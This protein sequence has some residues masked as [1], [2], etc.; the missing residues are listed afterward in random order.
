M[1][2]K[3]LNTR[4][5]ILDLIEFHNKNSEFV[6]IDVETTSVEPRKARL[7]DIQIS[8]LTEESAVIFGA[9]FSDTLLT[10]APSLILVA[11]N[12]R[13]DAHVLVRHGVDLLERTWRDTL[14]LGHLVDE[15]RDSYSLA[16]YVSEYWG[17]DYK[18]S[19][20][21]KDGGKYASYEE[22]TEE[23]KVEYAC[24]DIVYT[25]KLYRFLELERARVEIPVS[26]VLHAHKLQRS[27]LYTE[28]DGIGVDIAY[29]QDLGV[30][31]KQRID[32]LD[33][34]MRSCVR[35]EIDIIELEMYLKKVSTYKTDKG[36]RGA[37]R[38]TFSY[39]SSAQ[40][41]RLL[42]D[43]LELPEQ[44]NDKTKAVSTD[45]ASLEKI[46]ELH[47]VVRL[48]QDNRDLQKV[49]SSYVIGTLDR[50][51]QSRIYPSF[52]INGTV[53]GRISHHS[54]NLAQLPK[55]GGVRGL[56][57]PSD[58]RVF[59]S[60]DYS[61]L[62]IVIEANLTGDKNLIRMLENGES[63]HDFTAS[64]L[65]CDR[66]TAKTLNL[67]L[68]Y[69]C[70]AGKVAKLLGVS[71][72]EGQ[73]VY[74]QYWNLYSGSRDLKKKTDKAV[75]DG[76]ALTTVFGR[77]RRFEK[78]TRSVF[79]GDYRQAFNFL[80]QSTGADC[81]HEAF[82]TTDQILRSRGFGKTVLEVHDEIIIEVNPLF[83]PEAEKILLATMASVADRFN[84]VVPLRAVS[85]GPRL[86]WEDK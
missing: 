13:Y 82:Y 56:Y 70:T 71:G 54:P 41:R 7:V 8:G 15:N 33:P 76:V 19:F 43:V 44:R 38:P 37:Q 58:G 81:T 29:L 26:L 2:F 62:E 84:F 40:V 72:A 16:S 1:D 77:K 55:T 12:Y 14:L 34:Q 85:S 42:Y 79:D 69:H 52:R 39:D 21:K 22:A 49:Y 83:S 28:I 74:D 5:E 50:L 32:E 18:K 9:E 47:P 64:Q 51:D 48:I 73:R 27:L 78:K 17:S 31:L 36:K 67:A 11:H 30:R 63:K 20:W 68:Q 3:R 45:Y 86:R 23:D 66:N 46:K 80:I 61:Q 57:I 75:D 53:T 4:E 6:V 10:L 65:G 35:D 59:I 24:R 60:A 25:S